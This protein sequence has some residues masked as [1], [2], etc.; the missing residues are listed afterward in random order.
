MLWAICA[1]LLALWLVS[2]AVSVTL[3]GLAHLLLV[4]AIAVILFR[5]WQSRTTI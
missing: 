3:G 1:L 2:M 4:A 5:V